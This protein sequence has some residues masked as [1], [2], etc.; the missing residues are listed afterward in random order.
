MSLQSVHGALR[1]FGV[2]ICLVLGWSSSCLPLVA[3]TVDVDRVPVAARRTAG[4]EPGAVWVADSRGV[5]KLSADSGDLVLAIPQAAGSRALAVDAATDRLWAYAPGLLVAFDLQGKPLLRLSVGTVERA[6]PTEQG[7]RPVLAAAGGTVWLGEGRELSA[8]NSAGELLRS[9][10]LSAPVRDLAFDGQRKLLWVATADGVTGYESDGGFE[11]LR[12]AVGDRPSVQGLSV[13]TRSGEVWVA[14]SDRLQAHSPDG[15]R[16]LEI[17]PPSL[18]SV[19]RDPAILVAADGEG[20]AWVAAGGWL[21]RFNHEGLVVA[22]TQPFS[23][24]AGVRSVACDPERQEIWAASDSE[25]AEVS[26]SGSVLRLLAFETPLRVRDLALERHGGSGRGGQR[27][28]AGSV[29]APGGS[30]P[31]AGGVA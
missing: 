28:R 3:R 8:Y 26:S 13:D 31:Q 5:L 14:H 16:R 20:G 15:V 9:L 22:A 7:G 11:L 2:A 23:D 18:A 29:A 6:I 19:L 21:V 4:G 25:L 24:T 17:D 30:S 12:L 27:D 10:T 1:R